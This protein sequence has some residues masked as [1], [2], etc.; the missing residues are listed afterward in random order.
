MARLNLAVSRQVKD[1]LESIRDETHAESVT[2]VIRRAVAVY[3]FLLEK[4]RS[5]GEV[6]VR[7]DDKEREVVLVP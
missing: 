3:D 6:I 7:N 4:Q 5:G 2:E 1:R